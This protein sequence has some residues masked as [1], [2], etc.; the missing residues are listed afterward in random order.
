MTRAVAAL[1]LLL[2]LAACERER[3]YLEK[4]LSTPDAVAQA[5]SVAEQ[6]PGQPG[7][8]MRAVGAK[9]GYNQDNAYEVSQGRLLYRWF[10]CVGCHAQG[11]GAIGPA[12]MDEKWIYGNKPDEIFKTIMDG[13]PN[14]MPSFRGRIPEG[15]AWQIVAYV[16]SMSGLLSS[17][18]APNRVEGMISAPPESNRKP[19]RPDEP[20][21]KK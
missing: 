12:L 16:R 18:V 15:Q 4:P 13:R 3:R 7:R 14:G 6:Q 2:S 9:G 8:G 20:R 17:D 19:V 5:D 1:A 10:N 21:P 11:G